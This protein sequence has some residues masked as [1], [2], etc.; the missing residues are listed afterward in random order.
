M[1]IR[2]GQRLITPPSVRILSGH[3][4]ARVGLTY[5]DKVLSYSPIAYW[6]LNE[7]S[8]T[9]ADNAEGT[10]AR[11]GTFARNVT[12]M[13]TSAGIGDGN[14]APDFDGA[15]DAV[16]IYSASLDTALNTDEGTMMAWCKVS[17][18]PGNN[19]MIMTLNKDNNDWIFIR[20]QGGNIIRFWFDNT[21]MGTAFVSY[22]H[23][24]STNWICVASTWSVGGDAFKAYINGAQTGATQSGLVSK[25]WALNATL[26]QI[27]AYNDTPSSIWDGNL[28]HAAVWDSALT[29]PNITDLAS[30]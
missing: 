28:A 26:T 9:N 25:A 29:G 22:G 12:T 5:I 8:G 14:T 7:I 21:N 23:G 27:G 17:A 15:N 24:G 11:D 30:V 4:A 13:G 6:P 2:P 20:E 16:D 3:Q 1:L 18:W 10:A 19:R